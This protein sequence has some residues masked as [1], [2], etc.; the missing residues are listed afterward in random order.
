M[1]THSARLYG[2]PQF[3]VSGGPTLQVLN[4]T[5]GTTLP[6]NAGADNW[7]LEESLDV[8]WAHVI[9]PQAN[10]VVFEANSTANYSR[11][12]YGGADRRRHP[13]VSVVSMSF[14]GPEFFAETVYDSIFT[15]PSGHPGVTFL[16]STGDSGEP[17]GYPA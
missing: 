16:G 10:I 2:L 6:A 4:E 17:G 5:G 8:E 3:N 9:A 1:P 14:S 7:S 12:V 13:G 15:T 11:P